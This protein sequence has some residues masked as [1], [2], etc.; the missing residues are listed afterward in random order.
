MKLAK[1]I[2]IFLFFCFSF[3][4]CVTPISLGNNV[5][6]IEEI[7]IKNLFIDEPI[8]TNNNIIKNFVPSDSDLNRSQVPEYLFGGWKD[9]GTGNNFVAN[10]DY[11]F[12]HIYIS[13]ETLVNRLFII[14]ENN[15]N[16]KKDWFGTLDG[17][18]VI[19][20]KTQQTNAGDS[21]V[22]GSGLDSTNNYFFNIFY[23]DTNTGYA[24][25][26]SYNKITD[27]VNVHAITIDDN[28]KKSN[29]YYKLVRT[30]FPIL[31]ANTF[32]CPKWLDGYK[33]ETD[34]YSVKFQQGLFEITARNSNLTNFTLTFDEFNKDAKSDISNLDPNN[35]LIHMYGNEKAFDKD[36]DFFYIID[37]KQILEEKIATNKK[38]MTL[39]IGEKASGFGSIVQIHFIN[40]EISDFN[41]YFVRSDGSLKSFF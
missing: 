6:P 35:L 15:S 14:G 18:I 13:N 11:D 2:I 37:D 10:F 28:Q 26:F 38:N 40:D 20:K 39:Q 27:T 24:A 32:I 8:E 25:T 3:V 41:I 23:K 1:L 17:A 29:F 31:A 21:I 9:V 30:G 33:K 7:P 16:I 5:E 12:S 4:S 22:F 36:F 19:N 34:N